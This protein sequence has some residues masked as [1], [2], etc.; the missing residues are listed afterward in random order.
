M[1]P[2][3]LILPSWYPS[4]EDPV[5]GVFVEEQAIALAQSHDVA[6]LAP[7]LLTWRDAR[8]WQAGRSLVMEVR[9]GINVW[10]CQAIIPLPRVPG[11][12]EWS[13]M[14]AV[15]RGY[16]ALLEDFG[17]PDLIHAHVSFPAGWAAAKLARIEQL[18]MVL[19]E[20][21]SPFSMHLRTSASRRRVREA[22]RGADSVV[23][24]GESLASEMR[25]FET[26]AKIQI[27]GNVID[28]D[29]FRPSD[30]LPAR[31][32]ASPVRFVSITTLTDQKGIEVLIRAGAE[33][34]ARGLSNFE[35]VVGGDGPQRRYLEQLAGDLGLGSRFRLVGALD[36][37]AV[38]ALLQWSDVFVL[39]SLHETF[40]VV[41]AEAMACGKWVIATRS[42]GPEAF[43]TPDC[44]DVVPVGDFGALATAMANVLSAG[45][46]P[47]SAGRTLVVER[48]G[49]E[50]FVRTMDRTYDT[51]LGSRSA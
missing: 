1:K 31:P 2:R 18:P 4:E 23:A 44:G 26:A 49:V 35:I 47:E 25:G 37:D 13:Y 6:V 46:P 29:F 36:R 16:A 41:A 10:R 24:V 12:T 8:R 38:R 19:T 39:P 11:L 40:G 3:V 51:A 34:L 32:M 33:L 17:R 5:A 50:A 15:R 9:R 43:V 42:G 21:S 7:R 27:I 22:L 30:A 45:G 20:H 14:R 48:Y 28:T